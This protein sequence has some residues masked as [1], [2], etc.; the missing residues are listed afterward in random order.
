M[1]KLVAFD[2]NGT[3]I[4]DTAACV[5][6]ENIALAAVGMDTIT[7]AKFQQAFGIPIVKYFKKL[8]MTDAFIKKHLQTIED[9]YHVN[10]EEFVNQ[11]RTRA[12]TKTVLRWLHA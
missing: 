8:G 9:A 12:G 6:A 11:A 10:Y 1:I 7:I 5:R 3:M 2:W 4:S